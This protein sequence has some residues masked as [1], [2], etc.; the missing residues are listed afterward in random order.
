MLIGL[1]EHDTALV[2][3]EGHQAFIMDFTVFPGSTALASAS[4]D[5]TIILWDLQMRTITHDWIAHNGDFRIAVSPMDNR[6]ISIGGPKLKV[7]DVSDRATQPAPIAE[8]AVEHGVSTHCFWSPDGAWISFSGRNTISEISEPHSADDFD[9]WFIHVWNARTM[10]EHRVFCQEPGSAS[11]LWSLA[12]FS[13]DSRWLAWIM[14]SP[15]DPHY[16]VWNV[17]A[18]PETPFKRV[19]ALA[20][21]D[22]GLGQFESLSFDPENQ[23][24]VS[25]HGQ[26]RNGEVDSCVRVWDNE[27][28][29]LLAVLTGHSGKVTHA[30]FSPDG[31]RVLSSSLDRTAK[32]WDPESG[33]CLLSLEEV[34][35]G[36]TKAIFSPDGCYI[37]TASDHGYV[38]LWSGEDGVRLA[39]FAEHTRWVTHLAFSPDGRT[40]ASGDND[41]IVHIRDISKLVSHR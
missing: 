1:T 16:C 9:R 24:A 13:P 41:G 39:T 8:H 17:G 10:L 23:R 3:V 29:E 38:Q 40:L 32:V 33:A 14:W 18:D 34:E 15:D 19:P 37:A 22:P 27:T 30:N 31:R 4:N 25:T 21:P 26:S 11:S 2:S 36:L 6:I 20:T 5:G 35:E 12:G 7:W 28:S